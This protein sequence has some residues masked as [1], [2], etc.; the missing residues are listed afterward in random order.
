MKWIKGWLIANGVGLVFAAPIAL[1]LYP[2]QPPP[3]LFFLWTPGTL[4]IKNEKEI[5]SLLGILLTSLSAL[6]HPQQT[7]AQSRSHASIAHRIV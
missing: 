4:K 1:L 6:L 3:P 7:I 5:S 2:Y